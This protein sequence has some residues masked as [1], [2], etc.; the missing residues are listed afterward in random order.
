MEV[1]AY[2]T[3]ANGGLLA[4]GP[5]LLDESMLEPHGTRLSDAFIAPDDSSLTVNMSRCPPH[6]ACTLTVAKVQ[7]VTGRVLQVLYQT[8]TGSSFQGYFERFFS[9][10][11]S[12]RFLILDAGHGNARVN[13]WIDHGLLVPLTPADGNAPTYET[14]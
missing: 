8:R 5:V 14:W 7:P 9:W 4:G 6:G 3:A 11:P 12:G 10:D 1:R 13:G 2:S